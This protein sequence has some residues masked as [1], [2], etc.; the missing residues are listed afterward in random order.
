MKELKMVIFFTLFSIAAMTSGY[1]MWLVLMIFP[2]SL[3]LIAPAVVL[4]NSFRTL[5]LKFFKSHHPTKKVTPNVRPVAF[6]REA[7]E[8]ELTFLPVNF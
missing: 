6:S 1:W 5:F 8:I 4:T 2:L 7:N 3:V